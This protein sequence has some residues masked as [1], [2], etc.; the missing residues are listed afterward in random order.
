MVVAICLVSQKAAQLLAVTNYV[1]QIATTR[2]LKGAQMRPL[3]LAVGKRQFDDTRR[4][5]EF[6]NRKNGP[7]QK[8]R[9]TLEDD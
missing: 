8:P 4:N 7:H 2:D 3:G 9:K 6:S 1:P 5:T